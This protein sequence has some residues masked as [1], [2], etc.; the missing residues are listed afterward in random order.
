MVFGTPESLLEQGRM[1]KKERRLED[2]TELFRNALTECGESNSRALRA[3]LC[4][5]LAYVERNLRDVDAAERHYR[6]ASEIYRSLE[7]PLKAAHTIRHAADILREQ[8]KPD[9]AALLYAESLE[10]Y[11]M[12]KETPLLDLENAVRGFALLKEQTGDR[13]EAMNLWR[14]A[15]D[16]YELTGIEAGVSESDARI[17][18]LATD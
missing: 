2:A 10:I 9:Q 11:R 1:A 13:T 3:T 15:R 16:L 5:E 17:S 8:K 18:L 4:E 14:E 12:Q 7:N 6:E